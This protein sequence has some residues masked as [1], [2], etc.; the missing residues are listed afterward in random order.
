MTIIEFL[1]ADLEGTLITPDHLLPVIESPVE[2]INDEQKRWPSLKL[3]YYYR[4][5]GSFFRN[6]FVKGWKL[7]YICSDY[8]CIM[9]NKFIIGLHVLKHLHFYLINTPHCNFVL[10]GTEDSSKSH[11]TDQHDHP[12]PTKSSDLSPL[13]S[14]FW[15]VAMR[16]LTRVPPISIKELKSIVEGFAKSF[17]PEKV[18]KAVE[19]VRKRGQFCVSQ[20]GGQF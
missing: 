10:I 17:D 14:W 4:V 6:D 15:S 1:S 11:H 12:W 16:E 7:L 18:W 13:D 20:N 5:R 2:Q 19:N 9:K 8:L 3:C